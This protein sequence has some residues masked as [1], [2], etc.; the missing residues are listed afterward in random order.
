MPDKFPP[1][2][3]RPPLQRLM[4]AL[5]CRDIHLQVDGCGD[6]DRS[7]DEDEA[8]DELRVAEFNLTV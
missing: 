1:S 5:G 6:P 8:R 3:Q 2:K 7:H 4:A